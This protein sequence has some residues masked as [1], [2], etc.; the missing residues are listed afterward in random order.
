M[1][2]L[3][4]ENEFDLHENEPVDGTHF[5]YEWFRNKTQMT[6]SKGNSE[7]ANFTCGNWRDLNWL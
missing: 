2:N 6:Q 3:S 7:M 1:Q 4:C 5:H